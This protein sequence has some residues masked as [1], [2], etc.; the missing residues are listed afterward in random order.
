MI[1]MLYLNDF[2]Y[3]TL[4]ALP[5]LLGSGRRFMSWQPLRLLQRSIEMVGGAASGGAA[6][7]S[8]GAASPSAAPGA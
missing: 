5:E 2:L 8:V 6:V 1:N 4:S 3:L 7:G